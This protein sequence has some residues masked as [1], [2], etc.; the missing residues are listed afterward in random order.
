M[1]ELHVEQTIKISW[2]TFRSVD[3][4]WNWI[5][6]TRTHHLP[7][8]QDWFHILPTPDNTAFKIVIEQKTKKNKKNAVHSIGTSGAYS[9][10]CLEKYPSRNWL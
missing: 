1:T 9:C 5:D 7:A 8:L 3:S 4:Q 10:A 2:V 6:N